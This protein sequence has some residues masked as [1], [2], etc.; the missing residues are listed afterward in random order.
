MKKKIR[1][2]LFFLVIL[3]LAAYASGKAKIIDDVQIIHNGK[4]PTPPK[5]ALSKVHFELESIIGESDDPEKSFSQLSSFVVDDEGT[6]F[7]LDFKDQKIKIY[8]SEGR[9]LYSFG[10]KGQG[11]AELQMASGIQLSPGDELVIEDSLAKKLVYFSKEGKYVKNFSFANRLALVNLLMDQQGNYLGRDLKVDG[12]KMFFEIKKFDSELNPL[13]TL[14]QIEFPIPIPGSGNKINLMDVLSIYQ[15]DSSGNVYYG[16]NK[17]YEIKVFSPEGKHL[18]SVRKEYD[19]QKVTE[20]DI[21][22]ILDRM[23]SVPNMGGINVKEMFEFPETFPPFQSFTLDEEGRIFVRTFQKGKTKEEYIYDVFDPQGRYVT[24]F[25]SK[26][27][28]SLIK[29]GRIYSIEENEEGFLFIHKYKVSW[30]L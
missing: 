28:I 4:K 15:F 13:F 29:R 25:P 23:G 2:V 26:M 27:N 11:P 7:A 18:K 10:D 6:I 14:D 17:D 21:E 16:R 3:G 24:T 12:Q 8:D 1:T 30:K 5:G 22:E 9:F 20:E 19:R